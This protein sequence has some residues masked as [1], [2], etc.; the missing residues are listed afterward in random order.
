[1]VLKNVKLKLVIFDMAGTTVD[2]MVDG[3]PLILKCYD[4]AFRKN[5][6]KIAFN[7]LN[8]QR[9]R[10]KKTVINELGGIKASEI[11]TD[12]VNSLLN[13]VSQIKEM[14]GTSEIFSQL[15][16]FGVKTAVGSGFPY[17]V[18]KAI[19]DKLGWKENGLID[20]WTCSE[21]VGKSRP[22]P[23]MIYAIMQYLDVEDP[24]SVI[25]VDDSFI[26]IEEGV[27]AGVFTLGVLTGTQSREKLQASNPNE[28]IESVLALL[29]YLKKNGFLGKNYSSLK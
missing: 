2:D 6:I 3:L 14:E 18:S 21:I 23:A 28:V 29:P 1:M 12:F 10:D 22:D 19:I 27:C 5:G 24:L 9:G 26:G 15:H 11:Y 16:D 25:K 8:D 7:V 13:N 20:Y 4:D 17:D